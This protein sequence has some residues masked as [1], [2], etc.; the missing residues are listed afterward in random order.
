MLMATYQPLASLE[1]IKGIDGHYLEAG[2]IAQPEI[3]GKLEEV[4]C[5]PASTWQEAFVHSLLTAPNCPQAFIL[6]DTENYRRIDKVK[7]YVAIAELQRQGKNSCPDY[8]ISKW[9]D[10]TC[11][12]NRSEIIVSPEELDR[13]RLVYVF[14]PVL[15][16]D[17]GFGHLLIRMK[18]KMHKLGIPP[19][20]RE[21]KSMFAIVDNK[22]DCTSFSVSG[23]NEA[24]IQM[25]YLFEFERLKFMFTYLPVIFNIKDGDLGMFP[26]ESF[27]VIRCINYLMDI[28]NNMGTWS[29]GECDGETYAKIY[30]DAMLPMQAAEAFDLYSLNPDLPGR[31]D[32]CPCGSG[33]KFKKCHARIFS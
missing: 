28:Y 13:A 12:D 29:Y 6:L 17:N 16:N 21:I 19:L 1:H 24:E 30:A 14:H 31:N 20:H 11:P 27:P 33:R 25:K 8:E 26:D 4:W 22:F 18:N 7:H 10:E 3:P 2:K 23:A 5:F 9:E 15:T 32:P